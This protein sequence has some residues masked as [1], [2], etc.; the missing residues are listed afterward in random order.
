MLCSC[1]LS[2]SI[3]GSKDGNELVLHGDEAYVVLSHHF[4]LCVLCV[5]VTI[6]Y[7]KTHTVQRV[8]NSEQ[9]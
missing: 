3:G 5:C 9:W 4:T 6:R 7:K 2:V 1:L 8:L